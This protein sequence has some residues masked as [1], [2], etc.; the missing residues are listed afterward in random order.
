MAFLRGSPRFKGLYILTVLT[1]AFAQ[2]CYKPN[3]KPDRS[4]RLQVLYIWEDDFNEL[5]VLQETPPTISMYL[6]PLASATMASKPAVNLNHH[7]RQHACRTECASR[8]S[9]TLRLGS[10]RGT[11]EAHAPIGVGKVPAACKCA[12]STRVRRWPDR[13]Q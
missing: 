3:G 8:T 12:T 5:I 9:Q 10:Q 6:A 7:S 11:T 4:F 1:T 2:S 13:S